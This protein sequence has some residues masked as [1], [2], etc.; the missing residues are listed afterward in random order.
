MRRKLNGN[1]NEDEEEA[2]DSNED[3]RIKRGGC[4]NR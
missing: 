4:K 3:E 2:I 1:E